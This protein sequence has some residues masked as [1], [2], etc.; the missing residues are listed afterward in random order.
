MAT[1]GTPNGG[2]PTLE[3]LTE[4]L[5]TSLACDNDVDKAVL[6]SLRRDP[7]AIPAIKALQASTGIGLAAAKTIVDRNLPRHIQESNERLRSAAWE[8]LN[9]AE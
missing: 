9:A 3:E 4:I 6:A 2:R 5:S 8:A 1:I 7:Y